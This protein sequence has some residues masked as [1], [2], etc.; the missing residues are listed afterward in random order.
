[1]EI[2][3]APLECDHSKTMKCWEYQ[4]YEANPRKYKCEEEIQKACW[5]F[6]A[7]GKLLKT[8][9]FKQG[10]SFGSKRNCT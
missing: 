1:V 5:N 3:D 6:M 9:C 10:N 4:A 7:C 2:V 8:V